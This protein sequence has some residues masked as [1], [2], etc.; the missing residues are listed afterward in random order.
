MTERNFLFVMGAIGVGFAI[1]F[2]VTV[3]PLLIGNLDLPGAIAAGFV[4]PYST[5]FA[6]DTLSS[7]LVLTVW[8]VYEART[9]NVRYGW[10]AVLAGLIPGT[11]TG[12]ALYLILRTVQL[13]KRTWTKA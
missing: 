13:R 9:L 4:N 12:L 7:W 10:V 11:V 8:I 2:S 5:G 6:L 3:A 1:Y